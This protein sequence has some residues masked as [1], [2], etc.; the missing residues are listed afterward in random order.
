MTTAVAVAVQERI[1]RIQQQSDDLASRLLDIS[2]RSA[3]RFRE[4][5]RSVDH[6]EFLY[7]ERGLPR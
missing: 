5:F 1:E 6:G 2:K 7:D 3:P 4:P